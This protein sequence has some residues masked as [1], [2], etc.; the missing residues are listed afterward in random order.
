M[1]RKIAQ[2]RITNAYIYIQQLLNDY[3]YDR[4]KGEELEVKLGYI[5]NQMDIIL[6]DLEECN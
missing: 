4:V 2:R 6:D 5:R 1:D 3:H